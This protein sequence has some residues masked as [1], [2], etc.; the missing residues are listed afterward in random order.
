MKPNCRSV[1]AGLL[2]MVAAVFLSAV[3]E[4]GW[5]QASVK[6]LVFASAGF[7]ESNRIWDVSKPDHVQFDPFLE[8]LLEVDP[9]TGAYGPRLATAWEP[10]EDFKTWTFTLRKGVQFH[11]GHGEL[12][13]KD[14]VYSH[15]LMVRED[16]KATLAELWRQAD[17]VEAVDDYTVKFHFKNPVTKD[18]AEYAFARSG[19]LKIVSKAQ[20]DKE[21]EDGFDR[22][23][24]T[25]S[26]E[27]VERNPGL[28]VI[29]KR[30]ENHWS[31][32]TPAFEELEIR[33]AKE[34][35]TR[36]ALLLSGEAH[37]GDLPRELHK[38]AVDRGLNRLS[39]T[40]AV[41]WVSVYIGGLYFTTGDKDFKPDVPLTKKEVRQALNMAVDRQELLDVVFAGRGEM[42]F[43]SN[44]SAASEG[45]DPQWKD[46]YEELYAYNPERAKELLAEAGYAPGDIKV[47]IWTYSS[48]GESEGPAIGDALGLYF[49]AIGVETKVELLDWPKVRSAYRGK[50]IHG[51]L[52][53]NIIS[54]RP[55]IQGVQNWWWSSSNSH[56]YEHDFIDEVYEE[57]NNTLDTEKRNELARSVGRHLIENFAEIPLFWFRNEVFANADAVGSWVYPGLGAGRSTHF[58]LIKPAGAG[59]A[60]AS[61]KP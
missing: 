26:Y 29:Y 9:A 42:L 35:A 8:T 46:L 47:E 60:V 3:P 22:P 53:P 39:S 51:R 12:T 41:D 32:I 57:W 5:A 54:W 7:D 14:V 40:M 61:P 10:S 48:P 2:A 23:A 36:L 30:V 43:I 11:S 37:V 21:G 38:D 59:E 20:F 31:G 25:G 19:D 56:F 15:S 49:N 13:A 50:E 28:N 27:F 17:S 34:P 4:A 44:W 58:D 24:G 16:S 1:F 33:I 52:W 18:T 6:R 55:A 45:W